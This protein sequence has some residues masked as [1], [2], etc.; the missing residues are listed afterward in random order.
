MKNLKTLKPQRLEANVSK[1]LVYTG[2]NKLFINSS[3]V[4]TEQEDVK[5]LSISKY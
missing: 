1:A 5:R 3:G 4:V 2:K